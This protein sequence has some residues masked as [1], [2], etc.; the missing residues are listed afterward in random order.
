MVVL[1]GNTNCRIPLGPVY[2]KY[3]STSVKETNANNANVAKI[4]PSVSELIISDQELPP[5]KPDVKKR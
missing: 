1:F 5:K 4:A 2:R 3:F